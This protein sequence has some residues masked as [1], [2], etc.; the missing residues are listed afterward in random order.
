MSG[1]NGNDTASFAY[2]FSGGST[3]GV[4]VDLNLQGA[5]QNTVAAGSDTLTGIEN[6]VGSSLN[7]TLTGDGNDNVIEGGSGNDALAGG[8]GVDTASYAGATAGVTVSLAAAGLGAEH[9]Q[10]RARTR[11][12]ASRSCRARPSPTASPATPPPT[13]SRAARATTSLNPGANAGGIVDLLDGEAGSDTA[14]FAGLAGVTAT[15]NGAADAVATVGGL[16][17]RHPAQHRES[18]RA[19]R[20]PTS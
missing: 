14:S 15:L 7:D 19:A 4:T 11:S 3:T 13:P 10:R 6:L 18:A 9:R 12:A 8:G 5:A 16:P 17:G 2:A 20:A 1:G